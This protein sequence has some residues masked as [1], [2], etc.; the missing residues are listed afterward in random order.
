MHC[1]GHQKEDIPQARGNRLA[2]ETPRRAAEDRKE[3]A[4]IPARTFVLAELPELAL[5][6]P[7]YTEAQT[8][9]AEAEGATQTD[10]GW[11]ELPG[12]KLLVP[13]ETAPSLVSQ[14]HRTTHL[15]HDK[16]EELI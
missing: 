11:W 1:R 3:C 16:L 15:G 5:D 12:G 2:D 14:A 4:E 13:E 7:T 6:S 9:L 8:Q 10:K